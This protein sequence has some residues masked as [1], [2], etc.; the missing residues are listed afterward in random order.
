MLSGYLVSGERNK[1]PII[2][3]NR[4]SGRKLGLS[5]MVIWWCPV[6]RPGMPQEETSARKNAEKIATRLSSVFVRI[7]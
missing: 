7:G 5:I 3:A 1:N 6:N 4:T 2:C